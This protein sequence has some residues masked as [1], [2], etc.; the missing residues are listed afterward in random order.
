MRLSIQIVSLL[1]L[2]WCAGAAALI[3]AGEASRG[4]EVLRTAGCTSCHVSGQPAP[5]L[6]KHMARNYSPTSVAA[7]MWDHAPTAWT[8]LEGQGI[9]KPHL[10]ESQV[11]DLFAYF[12][13]SRFFEI[14][15]SA[16][17]GKQFFT[18]GHCVDCHG[19]SPVLMTP[20]VAAVT[21]HTLGDPIA[22]SQQMWNQS[23]SMQQ[24]ASKQEISLPKITPQQLTD[25]LLFLENRPQN[26][27]RIPRFTLA[28]AEEGRAVFQKKGC[29]DC[30]TGKLAFE[31]RSTPF[32]MAGV[33]AALWNH[34]IRPV[35]NRQ[36]LSYA[37]TQSLVAYIW[38]A[39]TSGD[40]DRG[41]KTFAKARCASCHGESG[42]AKAV[43]PKDADVSTAMVSALW[44]G[45]PAMYAAVQKRRMNWPRLS[46]G[47][48]ADLGAYL[49]GVPSGGGT[50]LRP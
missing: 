23:A 15:G 49:Q 50:H 11:S 29:V 5:D 37:E 44:D 32:T 1:I 48:I 30:H 2:A 4:A 26:R 40:P 31:K 34:E 33:A 14:T 6:A 16:R 20:A 35:K 39:R 36:P 25:L 17:R 45:G 12:C 43:I 24:L 8:K 9:A 38:A 22:L 19:T 7:T 10:S 47:E 46:S 21:W 42:M 3:A 13:A 41:R 27:Q 18:A 28:S